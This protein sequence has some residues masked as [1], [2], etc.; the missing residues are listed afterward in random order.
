MVLRARHTA[1]VLAS[2]R[3]RIRSASSTALQ[4]QMEALNEMYGAS[5]AIR[6]RLLS[7]LGPSIVL[8][9]R[10][11]HPSF[12]MVCGP[13]PSANFSGSP[14]E[15]VLVEERL[16]KE[17]KEKL[18]DVLSRSKGAETLEMISHAE[19]IIKYD[20]FQVNE[21]LGWRLI[22]NH[23]LDYHRWNRS[24]HHLARRDL[25]IL[26]IESKAEKLPMKWR[27][28][29]SIENLNMLQIPVTVEQYE[30]FVNDG[31]YE[32]ERFWQKQH[33]AWIKSTNR[34]S[35]RSWNK[36]GTWAITFLLRRVPTAS[37]PNYP[38]TG[39]SLAEAL[40]F[41]AYTEERLTGEINGKISVPTSQQWSAA[42]SGAE[43]AS[44][45]SA[46][47]LF[48]EDGILEI[49]PLQEKI[50]FL[51]NSWEWTCSTIG[52]EL[53][54]DGGGKEEYILKGGSVLTS[55]QLISRGGCEMTR[56]ATCDET[57]SSF[58][59]VCA[60]EIVPN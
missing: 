51:G 35:P 16:A 6:R 46:L 37:V 9:A 54:D 38:V 20:S 14:A 25:P 24:E 4:T 23:P 39:I 21:Q 40:A 8:P 58:R 26:L 53:S 19:N 42:A 49:R 28:V 48:E 52:D 56:P 34:Q 13:V 7:L 11:V 47:P 27:K 32:I 36:V 43:E 17:F 60:D 18:Y 29:P 45:S 3:P 5:W 1:A 10:T 12:E 30:Q 59:L 50:N 57:I 55:R 15:A 31:G 22:S 33:W 44:L 41:A 2:R